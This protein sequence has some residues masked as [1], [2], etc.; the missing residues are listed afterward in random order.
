MLARAPRRRAF[1]VDRQAPR[2]DAQQPATWTDTTP[3]IPQRQFRGFE[4]ADFRRLACLSV[5]KCLTE[6]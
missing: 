4:A 1:R 3:L 5:L 2:G 6:L